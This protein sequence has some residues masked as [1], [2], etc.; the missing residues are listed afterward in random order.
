MKKGVNAQGGG[1]GVGTGTGGS[2]GGGQA[3]PDPINALQ[4]L[5]RQGKCI[6]LHAAFMSLLIFV[7]ISVKP[8]GRILSVGV[9]VRTV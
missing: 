8:F 2:G 1:G 6:Y 5:A 9:S 7:T 3:M 4:T